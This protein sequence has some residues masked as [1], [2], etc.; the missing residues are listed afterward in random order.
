MEERTWLMAVRTVKTFAVNG[1][2]ERRGTGG[3]GQ[4]LLKMQNPEHVSML[5]GM[6]TQESK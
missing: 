5:M 3:Q 4:V 6:V 2:K 1:S